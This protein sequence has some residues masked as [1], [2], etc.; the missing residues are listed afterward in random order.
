VRHPICN[1]NFI[2]VKIGMKAVRALV[3]TGSVSTLVSKELADRLR[4]K[5]LLLKMENLFL[6]SANG[7]A[8]EVI[9]KAEILINIS[10]LQ[11]PITARVVRHVSHQ[12]ILGVDFMRQNQVIID[13]KTVILSVGDDLVRAP[14]HSPYRRQ[15]YLT[16]INSVCVPAFTE[17][18]IPA[19]SDKRY[20]DMAIVTEP[21]SSFQFKKF[22][23]ACSISFCNSGRTVCRMGNFNP[24]SLVLTKGTKIASVEDPK[25]IASCTRVNQTAT[26]QDSS[27]MSKQSID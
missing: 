25:V 2:T 8:L 24:F 16:N 21:L 27:S 20:D 9:G 26:P 18:I 17:A 1:D 12:F 3:D 23:V 13:Y 5:V 19:K 4:L 15:S 14:L 10:G 6:V 7:T 11:I 22:A